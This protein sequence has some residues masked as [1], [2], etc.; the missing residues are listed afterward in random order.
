[1][2]PEKQARAACRKAEEALDRL[3]KTQTDVSFEL[4]QRVG[5][6]ELGLV[7]PG[8][9]RRVGGGPEARVA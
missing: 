2:G 4:Y 1:M 9:F 7:R 5:T 8:V 6:G 3:P